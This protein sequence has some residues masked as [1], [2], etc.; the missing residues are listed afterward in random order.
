MSF[1]L[2]FTYYTSDLTTL[3]TV[4]SPPKPVRSFDDVI[5]QGYTVISVEGSADHRVLQQAPKD[6]AMYRYYYSE[7]HNNT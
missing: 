3:M 6:S 5:E 2:L 1:F 7:M 4:S